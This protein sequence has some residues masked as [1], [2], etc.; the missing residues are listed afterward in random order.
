MIIRAGEFAWDEIE[1][2]EYKNEPGTWMDVSRRVLFSTDQSK[3][4]T[5]YFELAPGGYSSLEHH[6]HEH[7]VVVLRGE[8]EATVG[9]ETTSVKFGDVVQVGPHVV[10]QFRNNSTEPFGILCIVDKE[11][12]RPTL[13][14]NQ[15]DT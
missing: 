11:R 9:E 15:L 1:R 2:Q 13:A 7:C 3:F 6:K 12:D 4:E 10:H 14:G 8:G 5:R